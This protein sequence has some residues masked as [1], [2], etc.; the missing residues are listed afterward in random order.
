MYKIEKKEWGF[1]LTFSG[2]LQVEEIE[3]WNKESQKMMSEDQ[4]KF[5]V[6]VDIRTIEPLSAI[7]Q[8]ILKEGQKLYKSKGMERSAVILND[9]FTTQQFKRIAIETWI[10]NRERYI[11]AENNPDWEKQAIDWVVDRIDPDKKNP[12][13]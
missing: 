10:F 1:W 13:R 5:S 3:D 8:S 12:D 2:E 9:R 4:K 7:Q 11:C 6:I